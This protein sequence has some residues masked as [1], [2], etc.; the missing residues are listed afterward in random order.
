[1]VTK[2][3]SMLLKGTRDRWI[4]EEEEKQEKI[5]KEMKDV[6]EKEEY[7]KSAQR[8]VEKQDVIIAAQKRQLEQFAEERAASL[9][10]KAK[11]AQEILANIAASHGHGASQENI[12]KPPVNEGKKM[13]KKYSSFKQQ[14]TI[15][16]N[17]RKF[18][19]EIRVE[20]QIGAPGA[21]EL[22]AEKVAADRRLEGAPGK[23]YA[24]MIKRSSKY[25]LKNLKQQAE[26][27]MA[28]PEWKAGAELA[29]ADIEEWL[30]SEEE[31]SLMNWVI[32][33][34]TP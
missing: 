15:T 16:E 28:P 22:T 30:K 20:D 31:Q 3:W 14:Q 11:Q 34:K 17:F 27:P 24:S 8:T 2:P 25:P 32:A 5:A 29:I 4:K 1:M 21:L 6:I 33:N 13:T 12:Y 18:I 10:D 23:G 7:E 19:G 26:D 9:L